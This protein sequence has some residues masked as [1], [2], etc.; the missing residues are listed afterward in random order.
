MSS[1]D[2]LLDAWAQGDTHAGHE[3]IERHFD[4]LFRFFEASV[5]GHAED[6]V[7]DTL[8]ACLEHPRRFRGENSFRAFVFG[9]ARNKALMFWRSHAQRGPHVDVAALSIEDMGAGPSASLAQ[10]QEERLLL[11]GLRQIPI[12]AQI[13]LQ[14]HYWES[15]PGP[16]LAHVLEIPEG[17]VRS[18]LRRAKELLAA[19]MESL[20]SEDLW[21]AT[22]DDLDRWAAR[23]KKTSDRA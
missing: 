16:A 13:L 6:L 3:L 17:T 20:A 7:Q 23:V 12:D 10:S 14:L 1:D 4:R 22:A 21:K 5:P 2:E 8:K 11:E 9:I 15:L 19:R 18:R